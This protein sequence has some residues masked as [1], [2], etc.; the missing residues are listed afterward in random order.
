MFCN[1]LADECLTVYLLL[2]TVC[3]P[4][5]G[6]GFT[7]PVEP[8]LSLNVVL[9]ISAGITVTVAFRFH[10]PLRLFGSGK[11]YGPGH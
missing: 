3:F 9:N 5:C 8:T 10:L 6:F 7:P 2:F 11:L 1:K 4:P